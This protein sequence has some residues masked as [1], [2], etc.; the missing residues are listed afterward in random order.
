LNKKSKLE[1][2]SKSSKKDFSKKFFT[3]KK[4]KKLLEF[5]INNNNNNLIIDFCNFGYKYYITP[6]I[7]SAKKIKKQKK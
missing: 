1:K 4:N 7:I 6:K 2:L 3:K 5:I